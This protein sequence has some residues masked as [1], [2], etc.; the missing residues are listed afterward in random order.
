VNVTESGGLR[1]LQVNNSEIQLTCLHHS[2]LSK[3][4][5]HRLPPNIL[6]DQTSKVLTKVDPE[7]AMG[8]TR[9]NEKESLEH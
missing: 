5:M 7:S 4:L 9:Y 1:V 3:S 2:G 6:W 8:H